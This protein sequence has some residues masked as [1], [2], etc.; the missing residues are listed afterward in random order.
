[1]SGTVNSGGKI[2]NICPRE[3][4]GYKEKIFDLEAVYEDGGVGFV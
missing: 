3:K 1:M 2:E 4:F